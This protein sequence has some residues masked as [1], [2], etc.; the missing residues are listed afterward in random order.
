[1]AGRSTSRRWRRMV[2]QVLMEEAG[3]CHLCGL[4]GANSGDHLI[5]VSVRPDLEY[6]REN[7]R[8]AHL[9]CNKRRGTKPIVSREPLVTSEEW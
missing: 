7:V 4:P 8:A 1:M 6:V 9:S 3:I 2:E 5:P